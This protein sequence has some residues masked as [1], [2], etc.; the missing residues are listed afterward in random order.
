MAHAEIGAPGL[1]AVYQGV[2]SVRLRDFFD[3]GGQL[4]DLDMQ[5]IDVLLGGHLALA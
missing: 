4:F 3:L 5:P 2:L 1:V